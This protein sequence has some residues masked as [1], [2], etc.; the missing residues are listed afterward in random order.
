MK[1]YQKSILITIT[2]LLLVYGLV[3]LLAFGGSL[4]LA[5][6]VKDSIQSTFEDINIADFQG[7]LLSLPEI[8]SQL[9]RAQRFQK[10]SA[11]L[12]YFPVLGRDYQAYSELLSSGAL[13]TDSLSEI[14]TLLSANQGIDTFSFADLDLSTAPMSY[15]EHHDQIMAS[16][17][18]LQNAAVLSKDLHSDLFP[19]SIQSSILSLQ[20][21]LRD[22]DEK[23][24]QYR[25][26][27]EALPSVLGKNDQH[28]VIAILQN[29]DELRPTG[30]FIGTLGKL[31]LDNGQ[32]AEFYTDDVY[33][34]DVKGLGR[35]EFPAPQP[36]QD[37]ANVPYWYLRDANWS[38]NFPTSAQ[39][40]KSIYEYESGDEGIDTVI[41]LTPFIVEEFLRIT[42]PIEVDDILFTHENLIDELQFRVEQE[43]WRIGLTE[44][45]RKIVINHLAQALKDRLYTLDKNTLSEVIQ[46]LF[47]ALDRNEILVY[48]TI[49]DLQ[50]EV[51]NRGW[52][53]EIAQ[54]KSDFLYVVDANL[55][56]LKTDRL[57]DRSRS[58]TVEQVEDG[59]WKALLRL[60]YKNNGHFD[61]RTTRYRSYV[62][63]Y[64]PIGSEFIRSTGFVKSDKSFD[65]V[66]PDTYAEFDKTVFAGFIS[67]EPGQSRF[68]VIEYYLPPW[69]QSEIKLSNKY[70]L[71]VQKQPG[72]DPYNF[73]STISSQ[74]NLFSFAPSSTSYKV[75]DENTLSFTDS[76]DRDKQYT[77]TLK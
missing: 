66:K 26:F 61:Y 50:K 5:F 13:L 36:I 34:I 4:Y 73:S 7:A 22:V 43:F 11:W 10:P 35:E 72:V 71:F 2:L 55:G 18:H 46:S 41:A 59:R 21:L 30:G 14:L 70:E 74:A 27:L 63:V 32:I 58:Y 60:D 6:T 45:D 16:F 62:R 53:G 77:V 56:A 24:T 17:D 47:E 52:A 64:V 19:S 31:S 38:P 8:N 75:I 49:L 3:S 23:I 44:Q 57:I 20:V 28:K 1:Y 54:N 48:T 42:G 69:L 39:Q 33:N 40:I 37:Y 25:P 68:A 76:I 51:E 12:A 65:Y 29:P 15:L 67:I 9:E